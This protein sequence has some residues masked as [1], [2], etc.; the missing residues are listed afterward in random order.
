MNKS[1]VMVTYNV[2]FK[3]LE[4]KKLESSISYINKDNKIKMKW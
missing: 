1:I 4:R 2:N 3:H